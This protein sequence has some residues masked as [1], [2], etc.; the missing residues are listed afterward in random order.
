M[1][2]SMFELAFFYV[3]QYAVDNAIYSLSHKK[4]VVTDENLLI[5]NVASIADDVR[6]VADDAKLVAEIYDTSL[7]YK[8]VPEYEGV[9]DL[10]ALMNPKQTNYNLIHESRKNKSTL[11]ADEQLAGLMTMFDTKLGY[12]YDVQYLD[13]VRATLNGLNTQLETYRTTLKADEKQGTLSKMVEAVMQ[14]ETFKDRMHE[15]VKDA[16]V[17][18]DLMNEDSNHVKSMLDVE[19]SVPHVAKKVK[20]KDLPTRLTQ[21]I[22]ETKA[23]HGFSVDKAQ[24][25]HVSDL[26]NFKL[27]AESW[28]ANVTDLRT[29][30]MKIVDATIVFFNQVKKVAGYIGGVA[31]TLLTG[32][33][34]VGYAAYQKIAGALQFGLTKA[35]DAVMV[36]M[37]A[38]GSFV[39]SIVNHTIDTVKMVALNKG[40]YAAQSD[41]TNLDGKD[42]KLFRQVFW[43]AAMGTH[44]YAE[45]LNERRFAVHKKEIV[46]AS[47]FLAEVGVIQGKN[48]Q[49]KSL[50]LSLEERTRL[51]ET[52]IST[53]QGKKASLEQMMMKIGSKMSNTT[54]QACVDVRDQLTRDI[55]SQ[56]KL[57]NTL[58]PSTLQSVVSGVRNFTQNTFFA[59]KPVVARSEITL[60]ELKRDVVIAENVAVELP[61]VIEDEIDAVLPAV[62]ISA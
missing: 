29:T 62:I 59:Q 25:K 11:S 49:D 1:L 51:V 17:S 26:E 2:S 36:V 35:L 21:E 57:L 60:D 8:T 33:A 10:H 42:A 9:E 15:S 7:I 45:A 3:S 20:F 40:W 18:I 38:L 48:V 24:Q 13:T 58:L 52:R 50:D 16:V 23:K 47:D 32:I 12:D 43:S 41:R 27:L 31:L 28:I 44:M 34:A 22:A 54:Y 61:R 56:T 39:K 5:E 19:F 55:A 37:N 14:G 53:L 46:N 4:K 6:S 30:N